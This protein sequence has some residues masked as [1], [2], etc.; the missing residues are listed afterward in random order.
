VEG[1][2]N[3]EG[4][5]GVD[6]EGCKGGGLEGREEGRVQGGGG[7]VGI[8]LWLITGGRGGVN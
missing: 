6:V 3:G 1:R 4:G 7:N 8:S 2:R 5:G